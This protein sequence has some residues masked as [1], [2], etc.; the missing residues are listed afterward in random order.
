MNEAKIDGK[1]N[2]RA[3]KAVA[4]VTMRSLDEA[5]AEIRIL[6]EQMSSATATR[7]DSDAEG[8]L[9]KEEEQLAL[10]Q[11]SNRLLRSEGKKLQESLD[12]ALV[13]L[14]EQR[15]LVAPSEEHNVLSVEKPHSLQRSVVCSASWNRGSNAFRVLCRSSTKL[16]LKSTT[17]S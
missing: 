11:E 13:Q 4:A 5:R 15:R 17:G 12:A 10:L 3:E 1:A 8:S 14:D 2:C 16:T 7:T 9:K 6:Q